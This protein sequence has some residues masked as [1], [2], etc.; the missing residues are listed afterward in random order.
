MF[1][2]CVDEDGA[3]ESWGA[4]AVELG[5]VSRRR[6]D[7]GREV[8]SSASSASLTLTEGAEEEKSLSLR[9]GVLRHFSALG[10]G[11]PNL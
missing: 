11:A 5:A 10:G 2:A 6:V 4:G 1:P 3:V 9:D 8:A 7:G